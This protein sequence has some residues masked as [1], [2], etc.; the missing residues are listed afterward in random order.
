VEEKDSNGEGLSQIK[1]K[2]IK[3]DLEIDEADVKP[4][5]VIGFRDPK[6]IKKMSKEQE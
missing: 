2:I 3:G 1:Q 4:E 6:Q 5:L